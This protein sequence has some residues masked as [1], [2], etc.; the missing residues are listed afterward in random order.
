LLE[1]E[2][3]GVLE[4]YPNPTFLPGVGGGR[5]REVNPFRQF[6][7]LMPLLFL[8]GACAN[9]P[10]GGVYRLN[11]E[12]SAEAL[13]P[14]IPLTIVVDYVTVPEQV[15]RPQLVIRVNQSQLRIVD[16][17]RWN[18]PL[19]AQIRNVIAVDVAQNFRDARVSDTSQTT[20][21]TTFRLAINVRI[22]DA[23][24]G[25]GTVLSIVWSILAPDST[26]VLNGKSVV[27]QK[28]N[29]DGYDAIVDAQSRALASISVD[30]ADAI[31]S[32]I[33]EKPH[34]AGPIFDAKVDRRGDGTA[35][36]H[37]P[38]STS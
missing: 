23:R 31:M 32:A 20:D 37:A 25:T 19:K 27:L 15:D 7:A 38:S 10:L 28:I 17:A 12:R 16:E 24:P 29:G 5:S 2:I 8:I 14:G 4:I 9:S 21:R 34:V 1:K 33:K 35:R 36:Q 6:A 11:P 3:P 26:R 18:E 13:D 22:F 30:M